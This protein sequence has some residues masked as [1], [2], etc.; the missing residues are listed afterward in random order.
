[1][2]LLKIKFLLFFLV[3]SA[4]L[5]SQS[6]NFHT[7][8]SEDGLAQ[9]F[10]YSITQD[11]SGYLWVGTGNG[12]SRYNGFT[13]ENFS[14][15]NLLAENFITSSIG[16]GK[17]LWFGHM[18]GSI[19]FFN[20]VK[21]RA[22]TLP[23]PSKSPITHFEKSPSGAIWGST[24]ADG[25]FKISKATGAFEQYMFKDRVLVTTFHFINN[26]QMLVG[27]NNGL[28]LCRILDSGNI[29]T[30]RLVSEIPDAKV[31]SIRKMRNNLGFFIATENEGI[32]SLRFVNNVFTVSS[33]ITDVGFNF[34]GVQEIFEDSQFNLWVCTFGNGLMKISKTETG[35]MS[36][37][38][39]FNNENGFEADN[40][41]TIF[42]DKDGN[43]WSGNYG[44]GLT[45]ITSKTIT[46]HLFDDPSFGKN[47]FSINIGGRY[48]WIGTDNGLVKVEH[49]SG[50]VVKFFGKGLG[51]PKDTVTAIYSGS[52]PYL[53][54]GTAKNGLFK[55]N[56]ESNE[57]R[58]YTLAS[59]V[60]ENAITTI[61]GSGE[62]VWVGT[63][64]G[65]CNINS[66]TN[67]LRWYSIGEGGLPHNYI[68]CVYVDKTNRV[69]IT[70]A[71]NVLAYLSNE[72]A[73][74]IILSTPNG[75][76]TLGPIVE[77]S[78]ASIWVGSNG[79]GIFKIQSDSILNIT[80]SQGLL[81]NYCYSLF[82]DNH[83]NIW[84]GHKGGL[85]RIRLAD[86]SVKPIQKIESITDNYQFNPNAIASDKNGKIWF[87]SDKGLVSYNP[88][89]EPTSFLPPAIVIT[90]LK[91]NDVEMG[92]A[93]EFILSPGKYKIRINFLGV[94]LKE[95]S[96]VTY[97]YS[98]EGYDHLSEIT[99]N[100]SVAYSLSEGEY[101]FVLNAASGD[102]AVSRNPLM[103]Q[104]VIKTPFWKKG[105]F[106][107]VVVLLVSILTIAY[108][109]RREFVFKTERR[110]L[111]EKVLERTHEIQ[112][113]KDEI[114]H[115]S[116]IIDEKN[117]N[118]TAS[119]T[120]ASS[121]QKA[122]L[123]PA[124]LLD[125]LFPHNFIINKPKDIVSGDF[126]WL[127]EKGDKIIFTVADC[128]GHGVPGAFMSF[129][130]ISILNSVV[131]IQGVV[132][133][134]VILNNLRERV[135][136][137]LQQSRKDI[138]TTD[139]MDIVLCVFD[140][141]QMRMQYSGGLISL[142]YIRNGVL[143]VVK[144][145]RFSV[146]VTKTNPGPFAINEFDVM[147]GDVFYLFSDGFKD[148]FG[149]GKGRKYLVSTFHRTLLE[150]HKLPMQQQKLFLENELKAWMGD[151]IQTDDVTIMGIRL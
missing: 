151:S 84:V 118:I 43:I 41:K 133:A 96:L 68:N 89:M 12:L 56:A 14:T 137:A 87:G 124:E 58:K 116:D 53:W 27:T 76:A 119:I 128:T 60:L 9:S 6:Y 47:V 22:D 11:T 33:I 25:L 121:I 71:T 126:Y 85:S 101:T 67:A 94:N 91:I 125:K 78:E 145:N 44:N 15:I 92:Y 136:R 106:F 93:S 134:N 104:F 97:Q 129:L 141:K 3:L 2:N 64:K 142:V 49:Q 42:E 103:I 130:G 107:P 114:E 143:E 122:I 63:K 148:Q 54:I 37:I 79:N 34:T 131:I 19:S 72:K 32:Y 88:A 51:L 86:L 105:W 52:E 132:T 110:I 57:I 61:A 69:W 50:R 31:T 99:K 109:K 147:E 26:N 5:F 13:F 70:T 62:Q 140:K 36:G 113:Q 7:Y 127:A 59:G 146:C 83:N 40:V 149:G 138:S 74:R 20:G 48:R 21:F 17:L 38:S 135:I 90:S 10:V 28:L 30:I 66:T 16:D 120:Y 45:H 65:L 29:E 73:I 115:Q 1:M 144:P 100:T 35:D 108:I 82:S 4:P 112:M 18:N 75:I 123:P 150:V 102:G 24:F 77:D 139:G 46:T 80:A 117:A 8:K 55:L 95:P 23:K 39:F 98:M 81:S 111:E